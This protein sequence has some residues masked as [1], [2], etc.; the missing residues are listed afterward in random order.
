MYNVHTDQIRSTMLNIGGSD[1]AK[2][3]AVGST[4]YMRFEQWAGLGFV[5]L[6]NRQEVEKDLDAGNGKPKNNSDGLI[7]IPD[8]TDGDGEE[9]EP[10]SAKKQRKLQRN[11]TD[12][13]SQAAVLAPWIEFAKTTFHNHAKIFVDPATAEGISE[14]LQNS[15][16]SWPGKAAVPYMLKKKKNVYP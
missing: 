3:Q 14:G 6:S 5:L 1:S 2:V 7:D 4:T 11:A 16:A 13:N 10:G 12:P 8:E 15:A 9:G